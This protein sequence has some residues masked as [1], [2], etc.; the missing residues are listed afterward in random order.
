MGS[1]LRR[2]HLWILLGAS[3]SLNAVALIRF[4]L[5]MESPEGA[6]HAVAL[7]V[8]EPASPSTG[9]ND[10][11]GG[12]SFS[13]P[14]RQAES[15]PSAEERS[16]LAALK[17]RVAELEAKG[18]VDSVPRVPNEVYKTGTAD[19]VALHRI[20]PE[21]E[22]VLAV[23]G[24][25]LDWDVDCRS[26]VCRIS[27]VVTPG[28]PPPSWETLQMDSRLRSM[29]GRSTWGGFRPTTD[30]STGQELAEYEVFMEIRTLEQEQA[31]AA[32]VQSGMAFNE[33]LKGLLTLRQCTRDHAIKGVGRL[34]VNIESDGTWDV[35][36]AGPLAL[37]PAAEC[38]RAPYLR[39]STH[40]DFK[41]P[42]TPFVTS[43][44]LKSP[45]E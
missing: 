42:T 26:S 18:Q 20:K 5:P 32:M 8:R 27:L 16:E 19:P 2:R 6:A 4:T 41:P 21:L 28:P 13:V 36:V 3:L 35:R 25:H 10:A 37:T 11:P 24:G 44:E 45:P 29:S 23:D 15:A 43:F 12:T 33:K 14:S 22:R 39:A 40:A 38:L 31:H 1:G 30:L 9:G 34:G 7:S 17:R